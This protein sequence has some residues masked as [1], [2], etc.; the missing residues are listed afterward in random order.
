M[1]AQNKTGWSGK[2]AFLDAYEREHATT[3]KLLRAYPKDQL[4]LQPHPKCKT[5]RDLA[6]VFVIECGLAGRAWNNEF[7]RGIPSGPMPTA[8]ESWDELLSTLEQ[9][10]QNVRNMVESASDDELQ[11]NIAFMTGPKQMG[12]VSRMQL[13]WFLLHDEI[14]HRGQFSIYSRMAGGKVPSIY[15]PSGDEPWR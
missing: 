11:Q 13:L 14:H 5:A 1:A 15:G 9:S 3:M 7:A 10:H 8:P 2:Q 12:A 4:D 6:F